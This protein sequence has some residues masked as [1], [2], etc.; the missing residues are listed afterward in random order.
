MAGAWTARAWG[1]LACRCCSSPPA[2]S[3]SVPSRGQAS[4]AL[5]RPAAPS[6]MRFKPCYASSLRFSMCYARVLCDAQ[7][8]ALPPLLC[9]ISTLYPPAANLRLP[10]GA[11]RQLRGPPYAIRFPR[12]RVHPDAVG[13]AKC[14]ALPSGCTIQSA[15]RF[16]RCDALLPALCSRLADKNIIALEATLAQGQGRLEYQNSEKFVNMTA[17]SGTLIVLICKGDFNNIKAMVAD[18]ILKSRPER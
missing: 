8:Y 9:A 16:P 3:G 1:L 17:R 5:Q 4:G 13:H 18:L 10:P 12:R 2:A 11:M 7:R 14:Y 15:M 6:A